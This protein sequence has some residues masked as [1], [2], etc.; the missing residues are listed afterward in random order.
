MDGLQV[1]DPILCLTAGQI[2]CLPHVTHEGELSRESAGLGTSRHTY[3]HQFTITPVFPSGHY[4]TFSIGTSGPVWCCLNSGY[5]LIRPLVVSC[6][7]Q[8]FRLG[9]GVVAP[10]FI[11]P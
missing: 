8:V 1:T 11:L 7:F 4:E 9:F 10:T 2:A 5:L 6:G 3:N